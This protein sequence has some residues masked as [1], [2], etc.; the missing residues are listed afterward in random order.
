MFLRGVSRILSEGGIVAL[1]PEVSLRFFLESFHE[2]LI[3]N[4]HSA[5]LKAGDSRGNRLPAGAQDE[6]ARN[7]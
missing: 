3:S 2:V 7:P 6:K 5:G 4:Q 1:V